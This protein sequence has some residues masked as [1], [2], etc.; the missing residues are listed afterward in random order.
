MKIPPEL[1]ETSICSFL[2]RPVLS[3]ISLAA[4]IMC[5]VLKVS[6]LSKRMSKHK[7]PLAHTWLA[8]SLSPPLS[9]P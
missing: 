9:R 8:V 2:T 6:G 3:K 4:E 1:L 5:L 7:R